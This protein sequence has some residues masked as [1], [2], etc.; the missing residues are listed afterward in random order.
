MTTVP[1]D[2]VVRLNSSS[3]RTQFFSAGDATCASPLAVP[4][5]TVPAGQNAGFFRF[6]DAMPGLSVLGATPPDGGVEGT[7][8]PAGR[9]QTLL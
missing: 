8:I 6:L 7:L 4:G 3:A 5:V 2:L 1:A 9:E